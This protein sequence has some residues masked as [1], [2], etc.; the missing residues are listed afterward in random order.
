MSSLPNNQQTP[1]LQ[2]ELLRVLYTHLNSALAGTMLAA[3]VLVI[4]LWTRID[5]TMAGGWLILMGLLVAVRYVD[6]RAFQHS[7]MLPEQYKRWHYSFIFFVLLSGIWWGT[8]IVFS[9][10]NLSIE[11]WV[12]PIFFAGGMMASASTAYA[13]FIPAFLAFSIPIM[14]PPMIWC[15]YQGTQPYLDMGVVL[16]IYLTMIFLFTRRNGAMLIN[17]LEAKR[18][19]AEANAHMHFQTEIL[20]QQRH[21]LRTVLDTAPVGIWML[22]KNGHMRFMNKAFC[23]AVGVSEAQFIAADHYSELLPADEVQSCMDSDAA[24]YAAQGLYQARERLACVDGK[25]HDF[26]IFK[27]PFCDTQGE[28][29]GLVGVAIAVTDRLQAEQETARLA[30]ILEVTPNLVGMTDTEGRV[31]YINPAGRKLLGLDADASL[32]SITIADFHSAEDLQRMKTR[33]FP[34]AEREGSVQTEIDFLHRDGHPVPTMAVFLAHKLQGTD[35]ITHYSVIARDLTKEKEAHAKMEHAQ[36]LESLGVLAGGIAHDFNNILTAIMGNASLAR[37]KEGTGES[38][39]PY[40]ERIEESSQRAAELCKQMLAYSGKGKFVVKLVNLSEIIG[41]ITR[42][43]EVSIAKHVVLKLELS[44]DIPA[45][46]VDVAQLRQVIMNLLINASDAM[47]DAHG[48]VVIRAG[49]MQASSRYLDQAYMS[50]DTQAGSYVYLEIQ[51]TGC[52]MS[53]ETKAKLFDPF[54]TTKFTG[55]GLGMSAVLGIVRGHQGAI[56]VESDVTYSPA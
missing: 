11:Y 22:Q 55:R 6:A 24:C 16:G 46:R 42:L 12:V 32:T 48:D 28:V 7:D 26:D 20:N 39:M 29:Q 1:S 33:L 30:A 53:E 23:Q 14:V 9:M 45:V 18:G 54:F 34:T 51:D 21:L 19:Q 41:D 13:A 52:G 47:G 36:R 38:S 4:I 25:I 44:S 27:Q 8:A 10:Q 3:S 49:V 31:I 56:R 2:G 43:L 17:T 40:L 35:K 15:F 50:P 37:I 5:H